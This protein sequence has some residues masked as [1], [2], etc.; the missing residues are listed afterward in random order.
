[1][2]SPFKLSRI[3]AMV[4]FWFP[5]HEFEDLTTEMRV[6]AVALTE[7]SQDEVQGAIL[8]MGDTLDLDEAQEARLIKLQKY[9]L[10]TL[11]PVNHRKQHETH[12]QPNRE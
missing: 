1:M 8:R 4:N 6:A 11:C 10:R 5:H 7:M 12:L 3:K 9:L 2:V